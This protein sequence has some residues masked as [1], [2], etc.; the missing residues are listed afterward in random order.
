MILDT[1]SSDVGIGAVLSQVQEGRKRVLAYGSR[2]LSKTEQNYCTTRRELLAVVEFASHFRQYLLG[3]PFTVRTDHSSLRWRT[4]MKEPEGQLAR[5]LERL[6]EYNFEI[7]HRPGRLHSN[8]DSLSRI[9]CRQS[10]PCKLPCPSPQPVSFSD[11]AVQCQLDTD[12]NQAMP[13]PVVVERPSASTA[14]SPVGVERSSASTA[15]SPVVVER[16]S[17]STA[18]SPVGVERSS[19]STAVSPVGVERSSASTAVSPVGVER[20][21]ASTAVSPVVVE[22]P[23]AS[24]AVSPVGVERSSASTAVS[25]VGVSKVTGLRPTTQLGCSAAG[26]QRSYGRLR[27]LIRT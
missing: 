27:R 8:A 15:V 12:I 22:R 24:T 9:P 20:S 4:Q 19:A 2:K 21:S 3:R 7:V 14:V 16:P 1:D 23:S 17:A 26:A 25:P 10:C 18:V 6:G 13:S 5:W 11:K